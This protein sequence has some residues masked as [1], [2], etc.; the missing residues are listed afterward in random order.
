[1]RDT[2]HRVAG[3]DAGDVHCGG[4][5]VAG[6]CGHLLGAAEG[7]FDRIAL[8][9]HVRGMRQQLLFVA[10][11]GAKHLHRGDERGLCQSLDVC[12]RVPFG[13]Q[14]GAGPGFN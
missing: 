9:D 7:A 2:I 10:H 3:V 13:C 5:A 4:G 11:G 8:N 1:M 14:Y 6:A 12:E